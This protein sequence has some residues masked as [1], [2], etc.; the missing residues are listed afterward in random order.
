MPRCDLDGGSI[1]VGDLMRRVE[2]GTIPTT[3][4]QNALMKARESLYGPST[5]ALNEKA[6]AAM[7]Q[8][9]A[10]IARLRGK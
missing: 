1:R 4:A 5:P 8:L 9:D 7:Q 2:E 3:V 6:R 10:Y